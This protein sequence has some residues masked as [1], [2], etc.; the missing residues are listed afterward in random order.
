MA[1]SQLGLWLLMIISCRWVYR[2]K[3]VISNLG[4]TA[5]IVQKCKKKAKFMWKYKGVERPHFAISPSADQESV[6]DYPRPPELVP[7]NRAVE[8]RAKDGSL[9]AQSATSMRVLETASPPTFYLPPA[10]ILVDLPIA[11]GAS[12]CEW[13]GRATYFSYHGVTLAWRYDHPSERFMEIDGW[14]SFYA[15]QADCFVNGEQVQ[16]QQ[17]DFYGGWITPEIVGPFKG[18]P[19]TLGW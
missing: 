18:D 17:G 1:G 16:A 11:D 7:D 4:L 5:G 14:Y 19:G 9:I 15:S 6:W 3:R 8:V 10:A 2:E 13:K 12:F